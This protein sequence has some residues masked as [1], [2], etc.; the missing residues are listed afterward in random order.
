[1]TLLHTD[2]NIIVMI[3]GQ[4]KI[5]K[6]FVENQCFTRDF[7]IFP[8]GKNSSKISERFNFS[9][10]IKSANLTILNYVEPIKL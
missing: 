2:E 5:H 10:V 1:M 8:T 9:Q 4:H 7:G 3:W 6:H